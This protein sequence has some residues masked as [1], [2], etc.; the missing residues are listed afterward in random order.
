MKLES[1]LAKQQSKSST[2][3]DVVAFDANKKN[4]LSKRYRLL[5]GIA[6][7]AV[8]V[9]AISILKSSILNRKDDSY[10]DDL[11]SQQPVSEETLNQMIDALN[12]TPG[13]I[14]VAPSGVESLN[15][16]NNLPKVNDN[17]EGNQ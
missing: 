9:L 7:I 15:L 5:I 6:L 1:R 12:S 10:K 17:S 8:A 2:S 13:D 16:E 3:P 14:P 11:S 4:N